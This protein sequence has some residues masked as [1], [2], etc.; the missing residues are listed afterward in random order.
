MEQMSFKFMAA[1]N[2]PSDFGAQDRKIYHSFHFSPSLC[3]EDLLI[4]VSFLPTMF[5][6][7]CY[8]LK[9]DIL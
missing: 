2:I 1:V 3:R 4:D 8:L 7:T 5:K 6:L 9:K